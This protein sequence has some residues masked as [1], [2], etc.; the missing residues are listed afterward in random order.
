[1]SVQ[2]IHQLVKA[3][4]ESAEVC[5]GRVHYIDD[6]GKRVVLGGPEGESNT[7]GLT[8][9]G[10]ALLEAKAK[11]AVKG[12]KSEPAGEPAEDP[13]GSTDTLDDL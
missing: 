12:R 7:F 8:D 1:M 13:A 2:L 10:R 9:A 3:A 6:E 4:G 11:K 5:G